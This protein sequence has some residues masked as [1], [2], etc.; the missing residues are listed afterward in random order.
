[1]SEQTIDLDA[2]QAAAAAALAAPADEQAPP[3]PAALQCETG[4]G[5][6]LNVVLTWVADSETRILCDICAL[7][8][9]MKLAEEIPAS[10][11]STGAAEPA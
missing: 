7:L 4:C 3:V 6:P 8:M 10:L 1:M 11:P 2:I 5:R 9:F